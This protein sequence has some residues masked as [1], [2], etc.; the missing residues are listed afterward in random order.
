M[1][2]LESRA[3]EHALRA[4]D[5]ECFTGLKLARVKKAIA[6]A[7]GLVGRHGMFDQYTRHDISHIDQM[8]GLVTWLIPEE[9]WARLTPADS[10]LHVLSIYLHDLGMLITKAEFENRNSSDW[11]VYVEELY[12]GDNGTDYR[13]KVEAL[14]KDAGERFLYQEYVRAHHGERVRSWIAGKGSQRL[15]DAKEAADLLADLLE[16]LPT[17]FC[18]D[19]GMVCESHHRADLGNVVDYP[20]SRPYG[21]SED[22]AANVQYAALVLRTADLLHITSDRTPSVLFRLIDP[23]DPVSQ[24]EWAKQAAVTTVRSKPSVDTEGNVDNEAPRDTIEVVAQFSD[25]EGFFGL[26]AYLTYAE[27]QLRQTFDWAEESIR[28]YG[29]TYRFPW[30]YIDDSQI[31]TSGFLRESFGFSLD[32]RRVLDLLTGHTLYNN[33]SVVMRELVQNSLDAIRAQRLDQPELD[34]EVRIAWDSGE[35]RLTIRDNGTGMSQ[36]VIERH[37]LRVGASRY[38]DPEFQLEHPEFSPISRFGIGVLSAFMVA[39]AVSIVTVHPDDAQGRQLNLRSVHGRYLVRLFDKDEPGKADLS[40]HGT[41]V[42]LSLRPSASLGDVEEVL[43]QWVV[44]PGCNTLLSIDGGETV[45]IGYESIGH[46]LKGRVEGDGILV[47][48]GQDPPENREVRVVEEEMP[49][50]ELAFAIYWSAHFQEWALLGTGRQEGEISEPLGTAIEGIRVE[51]GTPGY[52]EVTFYAMANAKGLSAPRT[53]VSRSGLEQ[54][55]ERLELLRKIYQRYAKFVADEVDELRRRGYSLTWRAQEATFLSASLLKKRRDAQDPRSLSEALES[56]PSVVV[57][58]GNERRLLTPREV[59]G[60]PVFWTIESNFFSSAESLLKEMPSTASISALA[61]ALGS[62]AFKLPA[63][64]LVTSANKAK[65]RPSLLNG[66]E[67]SRIVIDRQQ[68]RVDLA[69]EPTGEDPRWH[70]LPIVEGRRVRATAFEFL[71]PRTELDIKVGRSERVDVTDDSSHT[72]VRVGVDVLIL[73]RSALGKFA[74]AVVESLGDLNDD[75]VE[76]ALLFASAS[77][78]SAV[79]RNEADFD[80]EGAAE[81]LE[82]LERELEIDADIGTILDLNH[83][84]EV[85]AD[86][87]IRVFD[88]WAW[89]RN[90]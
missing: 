51:D 39:D 72:A 64:P 2:N 47:S 69:W 90:S 32:T 17:L 8:L 29:S 21:Q 42:T 54:T 28:R 12:G 57:D 75:R 3:E 45:P 4:E 13:A 80:R 48:E 79:R 63:G 84:A 74:A 19:L 49:G 7:L 56:I 89:N 44:V 41:A 67:V 71:G 26:T 60:M 86:E 58:D 23:S 22:E 88:A 37:L 81:L 78:E 65:S 73:P 62:D 33:T 1:E 83:F 16:P 11:R 34:G 35:R 24:E 53:D 46:A 43:R 82:R 87:P 77:I 20:V 61:G 85:L 14:G 27:G 52:K 6:E 38:Q 31:L 50:I 36:S 66:R 25:E 70:Q 10:L 59:R 5:L 40:P 55:P 68:R 18:E 15:G 76:D 30:K 9:T